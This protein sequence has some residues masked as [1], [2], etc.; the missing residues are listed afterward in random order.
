MEYQRRLVTLP[1]ELNEK[2]AKEPN[3]SGTVQRALTSHYANQDSVRRLAELVRDFE[4][5]FQY[6]DD[7]LKPIEQ[8]RRDINTIKQLMGGGV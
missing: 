2:L 4:G 1:K 8:M 5:S 3:A 7:K 6:I